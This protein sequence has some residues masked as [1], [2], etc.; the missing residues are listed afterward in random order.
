MTDKLV[1]AVVAI[2]GSALAGTPAQAAPSYYVTCLDCGFGS[3]LTPSA[4]NSAGVVVADD[5]HGHRQPTRC[6]RTLI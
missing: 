5:G 3:E 4:I 6:N 2:F 1:F